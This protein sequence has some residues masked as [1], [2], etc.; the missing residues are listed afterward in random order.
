M[1]SFEISIDSEFHS[2]VLQSETK[3]TVR[4]L[5]PEGKRSMGFMSEGQ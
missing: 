5:Y 1:E 2:Y 4:A 3:L